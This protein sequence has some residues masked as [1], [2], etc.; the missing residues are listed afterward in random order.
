METTS[1]HNFGPA[2]S[3]TVGEHIHHRR[4]MMHMSFYWG[5]NAVVLFSGWPGTSSAMYFLAWVLVFLLAVLL[6]WL[7][8]LNIIKPGTNNLAEGLM[9]T[10]MYTVRI[11]LEYVVMLAVMS[12]NVGI[13][14]AAVLGR[15]V[16]FFVFGSRAFKKT[17]ECE[18]PSRTS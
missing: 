5:H 11:G 13:F 8:R 1:H 12:F 2:F 16:G 4:M 3:G 14:L 18:D 10:A 6:E 7:S 17:P 9:Q 15:A